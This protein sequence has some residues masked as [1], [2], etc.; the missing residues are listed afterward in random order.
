MNGLTEAGVI[1]CDEIVNEEESDEGERVEGCWEA[2]V[3]GCYHK[4]GV[5]RRVVRKRRE[6]D[7]RVLREGGR[8]V[9]RTLDTRRMST[10]ACTPARSCPR[11]IPRCW[12]RQEPC[13]LNPH[14]Q[15]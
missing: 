9:L 13:T 8:R 12:P 14:C 6:G 11:R 15:W 10:E 2:E 4:V 5:C 1:Q 7:R 3:G